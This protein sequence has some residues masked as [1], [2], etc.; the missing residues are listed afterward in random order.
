M[1]SQGVP[2]LL[3]GDEI[4]HTQKGNNNAYCQDN[5]LTWLNWDLNDDQKK[6]L[7]FTQ[8]VV[9]DLAR[10]PGLPAAKVLP[11]PGHP[12]L[13]HQ[14]HLVPRTLGQR[15]DRRGLEREATSNAW[16]CGWPAT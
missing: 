15:D 2:M 14:G 16:A 11:G 5:E 10:A 8:K 1:L 7:E 9:P 13:G 4:G 6:F 3:A 12:R